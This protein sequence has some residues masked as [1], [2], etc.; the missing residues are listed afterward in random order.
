MIS[1][2]TSRA[3]PAF[4]ARMI[5]PVDIQIKE[6]TCRYGE[7]VALDAIDLS[8][9]D[10]R[11]G[12]VGRNGSGKS[13]LARAICG[14]V[15]PDTGQVTVAGIDVLNDR[16]NAI[17]TV[18]ILF[19]NPDHQIIFPTV[20]EEI[21][22]GLR[23]LGQTK[24]QAKD[25]AYELL[26]RFGRTEWADRPVSAFSQGQRHLICLMAVLA[27]TPRLIVLDEP[28]SGLD[29]PTTRAL[30]RYMDGLDQSV[31][32]ITHD[33]SV[34]ANYDRVLW[35]DG[36]QIRADGPPDDVLPAYLKEMESIDAGADL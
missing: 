27:M 2:L 6:L 17:S 3:V 14:L 20:I 21:T 22:F 35:I 4:S 19:Q 11:I 30:R 33:P 28:F 26:A 31:I 15:A 29:I 12:I 32:H 18:G 13:T 10:R 7:R 25:K 23:Q 24:S 8:L 9:S 1:E 34:I 16:K 36:G 5:D